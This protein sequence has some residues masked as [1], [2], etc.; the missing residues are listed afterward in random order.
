[1]QMGLVYGR[2]MHVL[3]TLNDRTRDCGHKQLL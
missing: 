1:M 2:Y 3:H